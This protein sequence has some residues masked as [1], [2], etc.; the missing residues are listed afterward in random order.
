[1]T[2]TKKAPVAGEVV[3]VAQQEAQ[4]RREQAQLKATKATKWIIKAP[5]ADL[6]PEAIPADA[7]KVRLQVHPGPIVDEDGEPATRAE[8]YVDLLDGIGVT[9]NNSWADYLKEQWPTLTVSKWNPF[10]KKIED[11]KY[12][13]EID[14]IRA[15]MAD[16]DSTTPD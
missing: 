13:Q 7:V 9:T 14:E 11:V 2:Q 5:I 8:G 4:A 12:K 10:D 15:A 1:M 16:A 6:P 3:T